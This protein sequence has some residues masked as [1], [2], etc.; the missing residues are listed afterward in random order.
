MTGT[1]SARDIELL[2]RAARGN[3]TGPGGNNEEEENGENPGGPNNNPGGNV[4]INTSLFVK[5]NADFTYNLTAQG[6]TIFQAFKFPTEEGVVPPAEITQDIVA[7]FRGAVD[8]CDDVLYRGRSLDVIF[9]EIANS[10]SPGGNPEIGDGTELTPEM[11][12]N[13][14]DMY[15]Q[16]NNLR[17]F[18]NMA[19]NEES[20]QNP[21]VKY[22][23]GKH[24]FY[25]ENFENSDNFVAE[26]HGPVRFQEPIC[27]DSVQ[28]LR[29]DGN[30][31]FSQNQIMKMEAIANVAYK[32]KSLDWASD[33]DGSK[34]V[35]FSEDF[36]FGKRLIVKDLISNDYF[37]LND[38]DHK[39]KQIAN[40]T[41]E[42]ESTLTE[43]LDQIQNDQIPALIRRVDRLND[44]SSQSAV[45]RDDASELQNFSFIYK[46]LD[47]SL[48]P[49]RENRV[50]YADEV[51]RQ[52]DKMK[53]ITQEMI[54]WVKD[55]PVQEYLKFPNSVFVADAFFKNPK[56]NTCFS[57]IRL[58]N[59]LDD[60]SKWLD[61][62]TGIL[63]DGKL[64]YKKKI[65]ASQIGEMS[66]DQLGQ[67]IDIL[68]KKTENLREDAGIGSNTMIYA[69][70]KFLRASQIV[71]ACSSYQTLSEKLTK[72]CSV[73]DF[74]NVDYGKGTDHNFREYISFD[75]PLQFHVRKLDSDQLPEEEKYQ[76]ITSS[77]MYRQLMDLTEKYNAMDGDMDNMNQTVLDL[78]GK[79]TDQKSDLAL[80]K[81]DIALLKADYEKTKVE[82]SKLKTGI[83][84]AKNGVTL[85]TNQASSGSPVKPKPKPSPQST[86]FS[87]MSS[88]MLL[89][90]GDVETPADETTDE[91]QEEEID[92]AKTLEDQFDFFYFADQ[93]LLE[94]IN[95]IV[96]NYCDLEHLAQIQTNS[97]LADAMKNELTKT[98]FSKETLAGLGYS[99]FRSGFVL[100]GYLNDKNKEE[101]S[102]RLDGI[103]DDHNHFL[104]YI[105]HT[106]DDKIKFLKENILFIFEIII[107]SDEI[108]ELR[109]NIGGEN[110]NYNISTFGKIKTLNLTFEAD[111]IM[112]DNLEPQSY[113]FYR[114]P[115]NPIY[116]QYIAS[117]GSGGGG[118]GGNVSV[119]PELNT[120]ILTMESQLAKIQKAFQNTRQDILAETDKGFQSENSPQTFEI[121]PHE[122]TI[123]ENLT[124]NQVLKNWE[125]VNKH[126]IEY[127]NGGLTVCWDTINAI[128]D[129]ISELKSSKF[130]GIQQLEDRL[131][132]LEK[133]CE[134]IEGE[135]PNITTGELTIENLLKSYNERIIILEKKC[136]NI[137]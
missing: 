7:Q 46:P 61:P 113:V 28:Y 10:G 17:A 95:D 76:A 80:T 129:D 132:V 96:D 53:K 112:S 111:I 27:I 63:K 86:P 22:H 81:S 90:E 35:I 72:F 58:K 83:E 8:F 29:A 68:L 12:K 56:D 13:L 123:T 124:F 59:T 133:K 44:W 77:E 24:D 91:N 115:Q 116:K 60:L 127:L 14:S 51:G 32:L 62:E 118:G 135:S 120:K 23:F 43:R 37:V 125:D 100:K 130:G 73:C 34:S 33:D 92:F 19:E 1:Y 48:R 41:K 20:K 117:L 36:I 55:G 47:E 54:R 21:F 4:N 131:K 30:H 66:F 57:A 74:V 78:D 97:I 16:I 70:S 93:V 134:N 104:I 67:N 18:L 75:R 122:E 128:D 94:M 3:G 69:T 5:K 89:A 101:M 2:T 110:I 45:Q 87:L 50:M 25:S 107:H 126:Q 71:E 99:V 6:R 88:P 114:A 103:D 31:F 85:K 15:E 98:Q 49:A 9:S 106:E 11:L 39:I 26:F 79:C 137:K 52:V 65:D 64:R 136:Q 121:S 108:V 40:Q 105:F 84:K 82:L 102:I 38:V 109:S 42:V 119:D